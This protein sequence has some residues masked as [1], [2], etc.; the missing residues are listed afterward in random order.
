M[1]LLNYGVEGVHY[2]LNSDGLVEFTDKRSDYQPW[3][4]GMGNV[5][6]LTPTADQ[7]ADFWDGFKKYYGEAKQI[8]IL[9]YAYDATNTETQMGAVANVVAE[10]ML[11]LCT[12]T[13]DPDEKLPEF[14]K[15]LEENGINDV[16]DD[17]NKQLDAYMAV[18]GE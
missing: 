7:G 13:V 4:N 12:G 6:I 10:Y 8:P 1:T 18:K 15:K 17:A 9:G 11:P 3:T 2:N 5:T 16:L 14:L